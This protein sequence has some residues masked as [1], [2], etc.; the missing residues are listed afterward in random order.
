MRGSPLLLLLLVGCSDGDLGDLA[1]IP[2]VKGDVRGTG[3]RLSDLN[4]P[5]KPQPTEGAEVNVTGVTVVAVDEYDETNNGSSIG[6]LYVQDL[7]IDGQVPPYGGI[8]LFDTSFNPPALRVA[9]GDVVDVRG[10]YSE[11]AG[12]SSSPFAEGETLPELVGG[13]VRLRFE[14]SI[15]EPVTIPLSDLSSYDTGRKWLGILVRVENVK[16]QSDGYKSSS[17]RF[18]VRLEVAGVADNKLPTINNALMDVEGT[19]V[20]FTTGTEY[21]SVVGVVQFF[22]NFSIS[23]RTAED[24]TPL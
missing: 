16:A 22:Y 15:P 11:F 24:I 1:R 4:D 2:P 3:A 5:S 12:P 19:Q 10:G 14:G 18:S 13:T 17:G 23:P 6:N 21:A 9:A 20:P 8:T 7:P